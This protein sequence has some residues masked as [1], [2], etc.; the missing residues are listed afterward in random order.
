MKVTAMTIVSRF[1]SL[2]VVAVD[3][4]LSRT[5]PPGMSH[6]A[7]IGMLIAQCNADG[8]WRFSL[9]SNA[10]GAG[11]GEDGLIAWM[12]NAMPKEGMVIGW[13]LAER[14]VPPLLD[15]GASG[16]PE[17]GRAFLDRLSH[18]VTMPCVDLAVHHGGAGARPLATIAER[19]GI[20]VPDLTPQDIESA[21][22][23]GNRPLLSSHVEALAIAS[24]RLWLAEA[25]GTA[26]AVTGAFEQW[27]NRSW[28]GQTL[29]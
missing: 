28:D 1:V 16:D 24:W 9:R 12:S 5:P 4:P 26:G 17:I 7:A 8:D 6:L 29:G 19:H 14:I 23:F 20:A 10:V 21:W 15:A 18:L 11:E 13:Q 25:N 27:A 22:A 2:A 3:V